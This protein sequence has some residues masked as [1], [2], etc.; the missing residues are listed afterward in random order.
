MIFCILLLASKNQS[1]FQGAENDKLAPIDYKSSTNK[2]PF[3]QNLQKYLPKKGKCHMNNT[4]FNEHGDSCVCLHDYVT[5]NI[6]VEGCFQCKES[7]KNGLVCVFPG[8]CGCQP[9]FGGNEC[10]VRVPLLTKI[11]PDHCSSGRKCNFNVTVMND[12]GE[13]SAIFCHFGDVTTQGTQL[14]RYVFQCASPKLTGSS[15]NLQVSFDGN[16]RSVYPI[17]IKIYDGIFG[18]LPIFFY[19]LLP[20]I[21][22]SFLSL[23]F[24][25]KKQIIRNPDEEVPFAK[26]KDAV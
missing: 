4:I 14:D 24:Y 19:M 12:D 26:T 21:V 7:C 17:P 15:V 13:Q 2:S 16:S 5:N 23:I 8:K 9:G 18:S 3:S 20:V 25:A 11:S 1:L 6:E 10:D 22:I